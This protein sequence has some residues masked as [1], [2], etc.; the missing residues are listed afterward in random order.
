MSAAMEE[1]SINGVAI[2]PGTAGGTRAAA[3]RELL[4]QTALADGLLADGADADAL[5]DASVRRLD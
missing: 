4:R 5:K 1:V 2:D 3:V